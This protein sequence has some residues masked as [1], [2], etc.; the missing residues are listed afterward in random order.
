MEK[1]LETGE[2]YLYWLIIHIFFKHC[3][4]YRNLLWRSIQSVQTSSG[5]WLRS[6]K[7]A[8]KSFDCQGKFNP[9]PAWLMKTFIRS[10]QKLDYS[11]MLFW[12]DQEENKPFSQSVSSIDNHLSQSCVDVI[13]PLLEQEIWMEGK[14]KLLVTQRHPVSEQVSTPEVFQ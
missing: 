10:V 4:K 8:V 14:W 11:V 5:I 12:H 9:S 1:R 13:D 7:T 3:Y 2:M 6:S